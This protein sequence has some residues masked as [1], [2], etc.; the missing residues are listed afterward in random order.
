MQRLRKLKL[1][2][3]QLLIDNKCKNEYGSNNYAHITY[4]SK[5]NQPF[6]CN[7]CL[8]MDIIVMF[9]DL[10]LEHFIHSSPTQTDS[11]HFESAPAYTYT[12]SLY[13]PLY[14]FQMSK[15]PSDLS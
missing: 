6:K 10:Y 7:L 15:F 5:Q 2:L 13:A 11:I 1:R 8:A 14:Q 12:H 9:V 4:L 3:C